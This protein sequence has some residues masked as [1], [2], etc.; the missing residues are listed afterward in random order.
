MPGGE[1]PGSRLLV[2]VRSVAEA[3]AALRGGAGLIDIKEPSR[4]PLGKADDT[5]IDSIIDVV[6]GRRQVSAALGELIDH[7]QDSPHAGL[8][9][10]K[11]GLSGCHDCFDWRGVLSRFFESRRISGP[12]VVVVAYADWR[13]AQSPPV[14]DIAAF[15]C[16]WPGSVFMIDTFGKQRHESGRRR[17]H[18]LDW[19]S[20]E[21]IGE[22]CGRCR[23][24]GVKVALAGSL[25]RELIERLS[26]IAPDWFA[27]R[28]AV[29]EAGERE[30]A[31]TEDRVRDLVA[32]ICAL[33]GRR[34]APM[35]RHFSCPPF[36]A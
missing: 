3:E 31:I 6:S 7:R 26:F 24:A 11:W 22:V 29:C 10:V 5:I 20:P 17:M 8:D 27:V 18:L 33:R 1:Q 36:P 14:A 15:A 12:N 28:G 34:L 13:Q 19:L 9:Y 30:S 23:D 21:F 32:E 16:R 2:S 35:L 4:G 25:D